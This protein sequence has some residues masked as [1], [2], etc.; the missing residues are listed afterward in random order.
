MRPDELERIEAAMR[1]RVAALPPRPADGWARVERRIR[2]YRV[3][4]AATAAGAALAAVIAL[5]VLF[6]LPPKP[7]P[8]VVRPGPVTTVPGPA[9]TTTSTTTPPARGEATRRTTPAPADGPGTTRPGTPAGRGRTDAAGPG[10][11]PGPGPG[12]GG[13]PGAGGGNPAPVDPPDTTM[14][15]GEGTM[16]SFAS[17]PADSIGRGE[18]GTLRPPALTF[19][20]EEN[21]N[22]G[23]KGTVRVTV[24]NADT[25]WFITFVAPSGEALRPGS[26][27]GAQRPSYPAASMPGLYVTADSRGCNVV[28]GRFTIH[29]LTRDGDGKL[30]GFMASFTQH[31]ESASR[32]PLVGTV[33]VAP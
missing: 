25:W 21:P 5:A 18:Q 23:D 2:R 4:R 15:A 6:T 14:A 26:Y 13:Q 8:V 1:E 30:R 12:S 24:R 33:R 27:P 17:D 32:P 3:Q 20:L 10:G 7:G 22:L 19:T 16:F 31:C 29:E 9:P 11:E 28:S